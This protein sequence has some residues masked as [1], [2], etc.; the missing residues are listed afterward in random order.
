[1]KVL[2]TVLVFFWYTKILIGERKSSDAFSEIVESESE[3]ECALR[4][5]YIGAMTTTQT[6]LQRRHSVL[7]QLLP[8]PA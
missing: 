8:H 5:R 7:S 6:S 1:M 2:C 3:V 4:G